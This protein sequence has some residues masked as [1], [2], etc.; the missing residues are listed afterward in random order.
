[1]RHF[2]HAR[3]SLALLALLSPTAGGAQDLA[4]IRISQARAHPDFVHAYVATLGPDLRPAAPPRGARFQAS[5]GARPLTVTAVQPFEKS[6]EGVGYVFLIDISRSLSTKQFEQVQQS[7][8][9]WI[10]RMG[11]RDRAAIVSFGDNV[12][13]VANYTASKDTLRAAIAG[14]KAMDGRTELFAA[15]TAAMELDKRTDPGL[16]DRRVVVLLSDGQNDSP[17]GLTKQETVDRMREARLPIYAIG[18]PGP[19]RRTAKTVQGLETLTE[20]TRRSGGAYLEAGSAGL[21]DLYAGLHAVLRSV[22]V[23]RLECD[24]CIGNASTQRLSVGLATGS[25]VLSDGVDLR[26]P[27]V[28][29]RPRSRWWMVVAAVAAL[30]IVVTV[31]VV[32]WRRSRKPAPIP[33]APTVEP[34]PATVPVLRMPPT[35]RHDVVPVATPAAPAFESPPSMPVP[36]RP[37]GPEILLTVVDAGSE[38][39]SRVIDLGGSRI[40]GRDEHKSDV[41]FPDD[42]T[43]SG[44]HFE[45]SLDRGAVVVRDLE[46]RNGTLVNGVVIR[47]SH[48]VEDG[49]VIHAGN[50]RIRVNFPVMSGSGR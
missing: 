25:A 4:S 42:G 29:P 50:T 20:L 15:I 19:G 12:R 9:D 40:I 10:G 3:L 18:Y 27:I 32:L 36:A 43:M 16:P 38:V 46:S 2:I 37:R 1:M 5:L 21:D 6:A 48:R 14:L 47:P 7:V 28:T 30:L 39:T 8:T 35:E 41:A 44:C 49:D 11:P 33:T 22:Y 26:M 23:L 31:A 45:F 13:M 17:K 24:D 34:V